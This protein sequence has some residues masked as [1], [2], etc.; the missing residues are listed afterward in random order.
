MSSLTF[1]LLISNSILSVADDAGQGVRLAGVEL[2]FIDAEATGYATFQSHN[3]KVVST[4]GDI[5]ASYLRRRNQAYTAQTWRLVRSRDRG[6]SF[7]TIYEATHAT[8]PPV[9]ETDD[10]GNLYLVRPDFQDGHADLYRFRKAKEFKDP[11][12]SKIP[13]G[14]AGKFCM[15]LDRSRER[16]FYFAHNNTFHV[17]RLD[18]TVERRVALLK[19]GKNA[20]LQYPLLTLDSRGRLHAAWTTQKHGVYMYWDIHHIVSPDNG[21]TWKD[22]ARSERSFNLYSIGGARELAEDGSIIGTFTDQKESTSADG[23][24]CAVWFFRIPTRTDE[25][26]SR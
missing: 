8:N 3:Q 16:L 15:L 1:L 14:A 24:G 6:R 21:R 17:I 25:A 13:G 23:G 2:T 4:K 12:I 11:M 5:F 19:H 18:G 9:L 26:R 7:R 20:V 22:H 10:D